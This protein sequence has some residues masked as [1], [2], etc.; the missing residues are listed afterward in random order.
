[1]LTLAALEIYPV[2]GLKGLTLDSVAVEPWGL[3]GDRRWM[4]VDARGRFLSQREE[5]RLALIGPAA[6]ADDGLGLALAGRGAVTVARPAPDAERV[7]ATVWR[8]S[9]SAASAGPEAD[10]WLSEALGLACRLVYMDDPALARPVD[11]EFGAPGD[12]VSFADGFPLL[13]TTAASLDDLNSRLE[14][15]VPMSRFRTNL[16]VDGGAAWDEDGWRQVK[17]G[18]VTFRVVKDCARCAVTT[19]DQ[20]TGIRSADNEPIRTL[21]RFRRVAGGRIIFGQN[22]VPADR[23]TIRVGDPVTIIA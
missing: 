22:L 9:V 21:A 23:G 2:K 10:R 6:L 8:D 13:V 18:E 5:P 1:M 14:R 4:V 12:T 11:Q 19:V 17:V 3:A 15:P 7:E 20:E 16:A